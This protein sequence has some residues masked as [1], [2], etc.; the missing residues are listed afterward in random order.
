MSQVEIISDASDVIVTAGDDEVAV[1]IES[2]QQGPPGMQGPPGTPG[3]AGPAGPTG[4]EGAIGPQGPQGPIGNTGPQGPQGPVGNTGPQGPQG[5]IGNTGPQGTTGNTGPQGPIGPAGNTGPQG[6]PGP[7][8]EA[9]T[10]GAT[11]VRK[12]SGWVAETLPPA[13]ATAAEY[14]A[15]SAPTKTLTPGAVWSAAA[16]VTLT[17]AASVAPNFA[18]GSDFYWTIGA[19]GRTLA[20]PTNIKNGQKGLLHLNNASGTVTGW[21]SVYKFPGGTKPSSTVGQVDTISYAVIDATHIH[22]TFGLGFA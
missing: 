18:L 8:P 17:D 3:Q 1:A 2:G 21:G 4:A 7:V 14:I 11:Y 10:D 19:A 16:P 6:P 5:P 22:C 13:A 12:S 9:P 20:N 15:N